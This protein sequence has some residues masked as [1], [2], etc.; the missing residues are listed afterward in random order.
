MPGKCRAYLSLLV[1]MTGM[2]YGE[3]YISWSSSLSSLLY[4]PFT[5]SLLAPNV[6]LDTLFSHTLNPRSS[7]I[8]ETKFDT[9]LTKIQNRSSVCWSILFWIADG[10]TKEAATNDSRHSPSEICSLFRTWM[11]FWFF[12]FCSQIIKLFHPCQWFVMFFYVVTLCCI[13]Y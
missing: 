5:S 1:L 4:S 2:T 8:L 7:L 12:K 11:Q 10:K 3:E 6:F 9:R 13:H